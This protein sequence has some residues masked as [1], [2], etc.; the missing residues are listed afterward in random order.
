M[1]GAAPDAR[2]AAGDEDGLA[3][4]QAGAEDR[5]VGHGCHW[6]VRGPRSLPEAR[7]AA[8]LGFAAFTPRRPGV[9]KPRADAGKIPTQC[10]IGSDAVSAG[11]TRCVDREVRYNRFFVRRKCVVQILKLTGNGIPQGWLTLEEAV[12]H[13]AAGEVTWE[14]GGSRHAARRPQRRLG[15]AFANHGQLSIIGVAGFGKVNPFDVVPLLGNDKLFRRDKC[16]CAYCGGLF[17]R[18]RPGARTH[19]ALS[20][21]GRDHWMNVVSSCRPCNQRKG[22]RLPHEIHM[23]LVYAPT[24]R[25]CGK[26]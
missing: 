5:L 21:G 1:G 17:R 13:Y 18:R 8:R 7:Q 20:R 10:S 22:N 23:P 11:A 24:C 3:G 2:A 12:L 14:L 16:H 26:T 19:R 25:A 6:E 9:G 4:E 15:P